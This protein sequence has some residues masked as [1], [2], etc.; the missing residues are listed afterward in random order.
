MHILVAP[1]AFKNSLDARE[2]AAAIIAGL[3]N[4]G[5]V[6]TTNSFP[7]ADGGDGTGTLLIEK[8]KGTTRQLSVHGPLGKKI[9]AKFGW[10]NDETAVIELANASGL[11]LLSPAGYDPMHANTFGTG[12]LIA[13]AVAKDAKT[14]LCCI[15]G[16]AT[17]DGGTGMLKALG[18]KFLDAGGNELDELPVSLSRLA[19]II[20]PPLFERTKNRRFIVLCDVENRLLGEQGSAAVFGPQKGATSTQVNQLETLLSNLRD[21]VLRKTGKD[22]ATI[23]HGGA[24]GGIAAAFHTFLEAE[25]VNGIDY[26]LNITRFVDELKNADL[27]ITG[28]GSLDEQTLQGKGPI[29]V[30]KMA[31]QFSIPVIGMAGKIEQ[32]EKLKE[33]FGQL[34]CINDINSDLEQNLK[35]ARS[36]LEITAGKLGDQLKHR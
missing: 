31:K 10:L 20:I 24:A 15:G 8:L 36:N 1:N 19:D 4:S 9:D 32:E 18:L 27:V 30:A 26:F 34:I 17:V 11:R 7:I 3:Q 14:I 13:E 25:L 5:L 22:M 28:E 29:G 33:Y 2:A 16:S 35:N 6:C 12:E 21:V 23:L